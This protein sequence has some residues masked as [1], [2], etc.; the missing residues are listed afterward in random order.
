MQKIISVVFS[1]IFI[2]TIVGNLII[3]VTIASS[4]TLDSSMYFFLVH[5]SF[6]DGC[7][8]SVS[9]PK[10]IVDYLSETKII[11]CKGFMTQV[12]GEHFFGG[13]E[14][15]LLMVMAYDRYVAICKPL[16]YT[17]IM[18]RH[19]CSSLVAVAWAGGFLYAT[20]KILFMTHLPFCG[21]NIID[22]FM[23]DLYP[24]LKLV[25]TNTHNLHLL[26]AAN[27]GGMCVL[28]FVLLMISYAIIIH[29]L[30]THSAV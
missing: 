1:I 6:I 23:C 18:S 24:L 14:I 8:P 21:P 20:I 27:S 17:T 13:A 2:L 19:L 26:V 28:I 5:L 29:S 30:K 22:H 25:S 16:H 7:Y 9:T 11:F 4:Q 10:L 15:I 3:V 12:I